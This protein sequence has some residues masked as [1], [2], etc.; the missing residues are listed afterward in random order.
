PFLAPC[1]SS[2]VTLA[3]LVAYKQATE[4]VEY[5]VRIYHREWSLAD[6]KCEAP[7]AA[8]PA[9]TRVTTVNRF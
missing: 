3:Y 4:V 7:D 2:L 9:L 6:T 5:P 1:L 8:L